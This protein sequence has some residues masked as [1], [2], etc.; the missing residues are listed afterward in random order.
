MQFRAECVIIA[1]HSVRPLSQAAKTSPSH[2]EGMGSIPVGVTNQ[3]RSAQCALLFLIVIPF[4]ESNPFGCHTAFRR[5]HTQPERTRSVRNDLPV[6]VTKTE[7]HRNRGVFLFFP[8]ARV[9]PTATLFTS[10]CFSVF[11]FARVP[12]TAALFV[13]RYF[14]SIFA[15]K[16]Q[17]PREFS[18]CRYSFCI[19]YHKS[20]TPRAGDACPG[21]FP[22]QPFQA[23]GI[24]IKF[25]QPLVAHFAQFLGKRTAIQIEIIRHLAAVKRN[26]K[27]CT[28]RLLCHQ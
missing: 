10:R 2:G 27:G 8:F 4:A 24:L 26:T 16:P 25:N 12:P 3:K 20:T 28:A 13:S 19:R 23:K 21:A 11:P 15:G 1:K 6:G 17:L 7:K 22:L 9:P 5:N 14:F 18:L